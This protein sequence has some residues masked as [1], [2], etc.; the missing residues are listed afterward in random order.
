MNPQFDIYQCDLRHIH[1]VLQG[2]QCGGRMAFNDMEAFIKFI[3]ECQNFIM[4]K[5]IGVEIPKVFN[6]AFKGDEE[7]R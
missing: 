6:D 3:E 1:V 7:W 5:D 2:Q 4:D